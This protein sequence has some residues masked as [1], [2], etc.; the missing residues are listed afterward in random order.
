MDSG[1]PGHRW[2]W[3]GSLFL[4]HE[5]LSCMTVLVRISMLDKTQESKNKSERE[6]FT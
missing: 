1:I 4:E 2:S 3:G 6:G 5:D